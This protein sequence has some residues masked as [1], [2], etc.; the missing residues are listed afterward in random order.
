VHQTEGKAIRLRH[1]GE[2]PR[3]RFSIPTYAIEAAI[4]GYTILRGCRTMSRV[5][6]PSVIECAMVKQVITVKIDRKSGFRFV[7]S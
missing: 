1:F 3:T 2:S 6:S 7:L 5:A 4:S